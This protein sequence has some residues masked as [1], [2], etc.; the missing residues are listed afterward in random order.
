MPSSDIKR[1]IKKGFLFIVEDDKQNE[2]TEEKVTGASHAAVIPEDNTKQ[3][4]ICTDAPR[5]STPIDEGKA[6]TAPIDEV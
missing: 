6:N 4:M 2:Q 1:L 5:T 3:N